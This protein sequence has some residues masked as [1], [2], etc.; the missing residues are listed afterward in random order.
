MWLDLHPNFLR[1]LG[2]FNKIVWNRVQANSTHTLCDTIGVR[3]TASNLPHIYLTACCTIHSAISW[4]TPSFASC[5][6]A[7]EAALS[8]FTRSNSLRNRCIAWILGL[9]ILHAIPS[10]CS[11][12]V[13]FYNAWGCQKLTQGWFL[14]FCCNSAEI[15]ACFKKPCTSS[16]GAGGTQSPPLTCCGGNSWMAA[17]N[18]SWWTVADTVC[19]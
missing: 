10:M 7:D 12:S 16:K 1:P 13:S 3:A 5:L 14:Q 17:D 2:P 15:Q 6:T 11:V 8:C 18:A 9:P 19:T 4:F